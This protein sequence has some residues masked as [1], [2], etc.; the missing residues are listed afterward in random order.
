[1]K[2]CILIL[3]GVAA[4]TAQ[5]PITA[6]GALSVAQASGF[7]VSPGADT[8]AVESSGID[9]SANRQQVRWTHVSGKLPFN[10][11]GAANVVWSADGKRVAFLRTEKDKTI[12]YATAG[13]AIRVICEFYAPNAYL[14]ATGNRLSWSPKGD[15]LA[16]AGTL[17]PPPAEQDPL[18][19]ER[20]QYK[21]RT[22]FSDHRRSRIFVVNAAPGA[23]PRALSP[24]GRDA[25]S[26]SW[27]VGDEVI[28]LANPGSDPDANH[29]YDIFAVNA[30]SGATR[31][32]VTSPGV[33]MEPQVSPDGRWIAYRATTRQVTTIDSVA[34]DAHVW[35]VP[36]AGGPPRELNGALDRRCTALR[37]MPDGAAVAYLVADRGAMIP[38]R[39]SLEGATKPLL[40]GKVAAANLTVTAR[41]DLFLTLSEPT[42]PAD[43]VRLSPEGK[44]TRLTSFATDAAKA[45]KLVEPETIRFRDSDGVEVEAFLYAPLD[46]A[47][48]WPLILNIHGGPHGMHGY[49]FNG[50]LQYYA[51][52]G[53]AVLAVNPRGSAGYGQRFADGCINDWGGGDYRD[54]MAAVDEVLGRYP[55]VDRDRL[56][57]MGSSYGGYM[58][59]WIV[60]QTDR[61]RAAVPVASLSNLVSFY[62]TSLYQDLVHAEFGGFPWAGNHFELLWNRSPLAHV[63][64][65]RTPVLLLHGERDNDVH[66]T[67]AEEMYTALRQRNVPVSMV[68]YPR[69]GHS[70]R[71]PKHQLDVLR[72][73]SA[74]MERYLKP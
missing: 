64:N 38:Y 18:V 33:E 19:V 21:T 43:L 24:A 20:I 4:A 13:G 48:R 67:Q 72:R 12:V 45:W 66:I 10:P 39:S 62:A 23:S 74:W 70:F 56:G 1:M 26:V 44:L 14:A 30:V 52:R 2:R 11:E 34:E 35:V 46:R 27:G 60:T 31:T 73:V 59:N 3:L 5:S 68:R 63:K 9:W 47:G 50:I 28:Y 29:N 61:F 49:A 65:V 54:L 71:E 17:E 15:R 16:F 51:A 37:W 36:Y 69:E 58:A 22:G 8:I 42:K 41:G 25:H 7:I 6:E 55:Q 57:A 53:Y 40:T 32:V